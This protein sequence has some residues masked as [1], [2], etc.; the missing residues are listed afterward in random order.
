MA[1]FSSPV[2]PGVRW[3][4]LKREGDE[5][6]A[7]RSRDGIRWLLV[8]QT[9]LV[10]PTDTLMGLTAAGISEFRGHSASF[11][12]VRHERRMVNQ[13][14]VRTELVSGSVIESSWMEIDSSG[15]RF[16]GI[17]ARPTVRRDQVARILFHSIPGRMEARIRSGQP[18]VLLTTGDFLEGEVRSISEGSLL[19]DSV[20]FGQRRLDVVNLVLAVVMRPAAKPRFAYEVHT[21]DGSTW[22]ALS[23]SIVDYGLSIQEPMIGTCVLPVSDL[24]SLELVR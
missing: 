18:G 1:S 24:V 2:L 15:L 17:Q 11:E 12:G 4:K 20:L 8:G 7:Y 5:F 10:L 16:S 3:Y 13:V 21:I 14:P 9:N 19:L 23:V 22:R 6:S